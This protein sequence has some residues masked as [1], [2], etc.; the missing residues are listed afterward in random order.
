VRISVV[1][2]VIAVIAILKVTTVAN[3]KDI[4]QLTHV[5]AI[6]VI[7]DTDAHYLH[8]QM[9]AIIMGCVLI[10]MH[11]TVIEVLKGDFV[12]LTVVVK[13]VEFV[14]IQQIVVFAILAIHIY[15]A[16][17][18]WIVQL[19][20]VEQNA[21]LVQIVIMVHALEDRAFVGQVIR[22]IQEKFVR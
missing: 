5:V 10:T 21:F 1:A 15:Q 9:S 16:S 6:K 11:A 20:Q 7:M 19:I 18:D 3:I 22:L 4:M 12:I 14:Q 8:V 17:V 13:I 2:K